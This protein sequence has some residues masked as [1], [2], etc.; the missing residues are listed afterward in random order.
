MGRRVLKVLTLMSSVALLGVVAQGHSAQA[1]D[2]LPRTDFPICSADRNTYCISE[3]TFIEVAGEVAGVWTPTGTPTTNSAGTPVATTFPTFEKVPYAGRFSYAGFDVTRGYDGVYVRVGPANEFTDT[4]MIAIEPAG[5]GSDGR[6]ARV[7][8]EATGKV[9]SLAADMGVRVSVRLG[10]LIPAL[11]VGVSNTAEVNKT[12]DGE[13]PVI[14]FTG[15]PVPVPIQNKST[16]CVDETGVAAAKP[17]QLFAIVVFENGRDPFGIPGLSGD[18]LISSNGV[19]KLT[20]PT[21]S[22]ET[23]SFSF[24]AS[25]PHFAPD[26]TTVNRGF[27]R[28]MI[29]TTDAGMLFGISNPAQAATALDLVFEDTEFGQV[30]V[31]KRVAVQKAKT[32]EEIDPKTKKK[33]TKVIRAEQIVISFTNF[34]FSS[35]KMTVKVKAAKL[36][37]FKSSQKNLFTKNQAINR[38][39]K[40]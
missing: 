19:C 40:D 33:T 2:I 9:R 23:L 26:G 25:A 7:K 12:I 39:N 15:Y 17:Y 34:Q 36:K 38:K 28:A 1:A 3:V 13:T 6:V 8:D 29:P 21:W 35:P 14:T 16:D 30:S 4:M 32:K 37:Q 31:E 24:I 20:S 27:Y 10:S 18:I 22:A 5:T 11:T